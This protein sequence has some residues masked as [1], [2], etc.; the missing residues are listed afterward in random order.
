MKK[1][2]VTLWDSSWVTLLRCLEL[3]ETKVHTQLRDI[4][5]ITTTDRKIVR[6]PN[7]KPKKETFQTVNVG[8][9]YDAIVKQVKSQLPTECIVYL[10]AWGRSNRTIDRLL[11]KEAKE[12]KGT[13]WDEGEEQ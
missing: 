9:L 6:H 4:K 2:K 3:P 12:V 13:L 5:I 8:K 1:V 10:D 11:K 7:G